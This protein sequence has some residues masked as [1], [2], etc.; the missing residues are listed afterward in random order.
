MKNYKVTTTKKLFHIIT[1]YLMC[2]NK[3]LWLI[4]S[5]NSKLLPLKVWLG[6]VFTDNTEDD[7]TSNRLVK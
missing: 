6:A 4:F 5:Q 2:K 7:T 3:R 1:Y